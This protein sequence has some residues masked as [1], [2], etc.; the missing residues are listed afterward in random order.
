[1]DLQ[2]EE[3]IALETVWNKDKSGTQQSYVFNIHV[4]KN[5]KFYRWTISPL[6]LFL[7][8]KKRLWLISKATISI[9]ANNNLLLWTEP[10]ISS[11]PNTWFLHWAISTTSSRNHLL[12]FLC[13]DRVYLITWC[14]LCSSDWLWKLAIHLPQLPG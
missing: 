13:M 4:S 11:I 1:M 2:I 7:M 12:L 9:T 8:E 5:E 10:S 14:L 3:N 6:F